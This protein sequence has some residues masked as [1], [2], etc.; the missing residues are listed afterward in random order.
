MTTPQLEARRQ[1]LQTDLD[2]LKPKRERNANGQFGTPYGLAEAILAQSARL[3]PSGAKVRF[4]DPAI[5]TGVFYSALTATFPPTQIE[6]ATGFEVDE[7]YGIPAAALWESSRLDYRTEDFT[8]RPLPVAEGKYNLIV[9]NPPYVRHHHLREQK[10]RLK[11]KSLLGA[12][13]NLSG[14]AGLHCHFMAL[15][16]SWMRHNG[17][18]CWLLPSGVMDVNYGAEIKRYL[19]NEVTLLRVHRFDPVVTQF[20]DAQV[21]SSVIWLQNRKPDAEHTVAFT[22]GDDLGSP[23]HEE[24]IPIA[25]LA[26]KKKWSREFTSGKSRESSGPKIKD[27]FTVRRGIATGDNDFF[28][29]S[30][31][32]IEVR[33]LPLEQFRPILPAPRYLHVT[34]VETDRCGHPDI[35]NQLFVLD[36]TLQIEEVRSAYPNLYKYLT[37]GIRAGVPEKYLCKH[38]KIWYAQELRRDSRFYCTYIGRRSSQRENPFRFVLNKSKAIVSNSYLILYPKPVVEQA[39][40]QRPTLVERI[41]HA[42]SGISGDVMA[43]NGRVYGGGMYKLEPKELL[44]LPANCMTALLG[45]DLPGSNTGEAAIVGRAQLSD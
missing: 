24:N 29:L 34:E 45:G 16:H 20:G 36:C 43:N 25:G 27:F 7:H 39:I 38:R 40:V 21:A 19:L 11:A 13:V 9:C 8:K 30:R 10:E 42:L 18:G 26:P 17:L 14:L 15:A 41:H 28:I 23:S 1:R 6:L 3:L 2:K 5:G 12:N 44:D 32:E 4:L 31:N 37:E 35:D 22:Q 33:G